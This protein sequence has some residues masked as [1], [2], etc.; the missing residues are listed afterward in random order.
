MV[1]KNNASTIATWTLIGVMIIEM[2]LKYFNITVDH[3]TVVML[4]TGIITFIVAV[5]SSKHPNS[6]GFLGNDN[7]VIDSAEPV[8]NDEYETGDVDEQ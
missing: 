7:N 8:L 5:Y 3:E 4:V 2:I 1:T 6:L